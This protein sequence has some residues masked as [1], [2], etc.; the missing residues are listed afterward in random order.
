MLY[1]QDFLTGLL[2]SMKNV[3]LKAA[4]LLRL[5]AYDFKAKYAGSALGVLWAV[6]EPIVTVLV[7]WFVYSVAFGA[8]N[9]D[10]PY[11]L[12][13]SVG[14]APWFFIDGGIR[15]TAA[16]FRDYSYL[17]KKMHFD[18]KILPAVRCVSALFSHLIFMVVVVILCA[19]EGIHLSGVIYI[20]PIMIFAWIF[21]YSV[22]RILALISARYRDILNVLG[23]SL[24]IGFWLTPIFWNVNVVSD[25]LY[26]I[27][28]LNPVAILVESYRDA[29]IL[30]RILNAERFLYLGVFCAV[31]LIAGGICEKYH[32]KNI[33]DSL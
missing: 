28:M 7:Y 16:C 14:I 13:L 6:S 22:G 2:S 30:G 31:M 5:A 24:N 19:I 25:R 8:E 12:W 21:V 32:I 10:V 11:Y 27:I 17:V 3:F 1:R 29:L 4:R 18:V 9:F 26:N 15:G 23:I 33:A 20:L